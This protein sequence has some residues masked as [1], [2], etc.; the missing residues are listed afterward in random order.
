M[1]ADHKRMSRMLGYCLTLDT[2]EAWSGFCVV[3]SVRLT[4]AERV[5]LAVSALSSLEPGHA[6]MTAAGVIGAAGVPLPP[7]LGG[8]DRARFWA[9]CASR[10][11]LKAYALASFEA[12]PP[13][14]RA[15]FFRH[16]S[17]MEVAA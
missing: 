11:E 10:S 5:S 13:K 16:I 9:S 12:M 14:D 8:M 2:P 6:E 17:K 4:V 15:A 1:L 3:A 7:F